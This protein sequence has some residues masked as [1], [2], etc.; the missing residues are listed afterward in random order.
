MENQKIVLKQRLHKAIPK[1]NITYWICD[2]LV[3]TQ[4]KVHHR[5]LIGTIIIMFGSCLFLAGSFPAIIFTHVCG[6][7]FDGIGV[8]PWLEIF[9]K[10]QK[11]NK[12]EK[13]HS[14]N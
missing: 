6:V 9:L 11:I 14:K 2:H 7:I 12:I 8:V 4:H 3:G 10:Q 13:Q 5:L 1:L